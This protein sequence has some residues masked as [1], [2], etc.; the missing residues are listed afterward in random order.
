MRHSHKSTRVISL[1]NQPQPGINVNEENQPVTRGGGEGERREPVAPRLPR[2]VNIHWIIFFFLFFFFFF[3]FSFFFFFILLKATS[4]TS[5][6]NEFPTCG[7]SL[8]SHRTIQFC[9]HF[10]RTDPSGKLLNR[11]H[12]FQRLATHR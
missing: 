5:T 2:R 11:W 7:S 1:I 9:I 3:F 10:L 8:D 12:D 6:S 4:S